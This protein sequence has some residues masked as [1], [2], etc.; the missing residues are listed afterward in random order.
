MMLPDPIYLC[1]R[2]ASYP[3]KRP[4]QGR[5]YYQESHSNKIVKW[6]SSKHVVARSH[7]DVTQT[8][9]SQWLWNIPY[10]NLLYFILLIDYSFIFYYYYYSNYYYSNLPIYL[11]TYILTLY[12]TVGLYVRYSARMSDISHRSVGRSI[13]PVAFSFAILIFGAVTRRGQGD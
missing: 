8:R 4:K 1:D 10:F 5:F 9:S 7:K 11:N 13:R 12:T 3:H 2:M 6:L